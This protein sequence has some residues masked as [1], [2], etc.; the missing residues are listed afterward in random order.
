M[1]SLDVMVVPSLVMT[2]EM[3]SLVGIQITILMVS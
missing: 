2:G 1:A 3:S